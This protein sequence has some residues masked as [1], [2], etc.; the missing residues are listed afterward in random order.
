MVSIVICECVLGLFRAFAGLG[1]GL[2]GI[3]IVVTNENAFS[4]ELAW[5]GVIG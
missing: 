3:K 2:M 4:I 1:L 5:G